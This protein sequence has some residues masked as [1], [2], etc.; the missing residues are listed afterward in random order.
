MIN[1]TNKIKKLQNTDLSKII[2]KRLKEFK[3]LGKKGND[4]WFCELCFCILTAN[5][6]ASTALNIQNE[7]GSQGFLCKSKNSICDCI[8]K[9]KHRFH[10]NKSKY[11]FEARTFKNIKDILINEQDPRCWLAKNIKGLGYKEASHFLRNVGYDNYAI[12]DRHVINVL[13]DN[14]IL[15]K[16]KVINPKMYFEIEKKLDVIAKKLCMTQAEL[17]LYIWYLKT[18]KVLK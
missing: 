13:V 15:I 10:N 4:E 12:V 1:L 16:P 14:N 18:G 3:L 5:S 2:T 6:K 11:I 8:K 17:D 7:L 9:N